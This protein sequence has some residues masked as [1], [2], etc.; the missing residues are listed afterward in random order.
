MP[1]HFSKSV[2][3]FLELPNTTVR[4]SISGKCVNRGAGYALEIPVTYTLQQP[5]EAIEWV[6]K[7]V[8]RKLT[9]VN[10]TKKN[11]QNKYEE[12]LFDIKW[13][14]CFFYPGR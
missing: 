14:L 4:C 7:V 1:L 5:Q 9:H 11:V 12:V 8:V 2:C 10:N 3:K 13:H 6:K